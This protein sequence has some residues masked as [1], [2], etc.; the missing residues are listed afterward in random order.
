MIFSINTNLWIAAS[1]TLLTF[2]NYNHSLISTTKSLNLNAF[3]WTIIVTDYINFKMTW[4]EWTA[5]VWDLVWL[6]YSNLWLSC[7]QTKRH[8]AL[9]MLLY[10]FQCALRFHLLSI[11]CIPALLH[12]ALTLN[13]NIST[14]L[15]HLPHTSSTPWQKQPLTLKDRSGA[16]QSPQKWLK[17]HTELVVFC[18]SPK[19]SLNTHRMTPHLQSTKL[20][21]SI[22]SFLVP[23]RK[24]ISRML[25]NIGTHS[26]TGGSL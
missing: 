26:I 21:V 14:D 12:F 16:K 1:M 4:V 3:S 15:S 17:A 7:T 8:L 20:L 2:F 19:S 10:I 13:L 18:C 22:A 25:I 23:S 24:E 6:L 11:G 9:L 5:C